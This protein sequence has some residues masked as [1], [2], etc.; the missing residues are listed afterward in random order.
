MR[1][2]NFNFLDKFKKICYNYF[3]KL[4]KKKRKNFLTFSKKYVII[5]LEKL[6]KKK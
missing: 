4:S 6:R 3:R 5:I 1:K 2:L